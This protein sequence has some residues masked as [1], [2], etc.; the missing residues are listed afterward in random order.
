MAPQLGKDMKMRNLFSRTIVAVMYDRKGVSA[1]EYA[2]LA[3]A[4]L[5]A[6]G[7]AATTLAGDIST[8]LSN[9]GAKIALLAS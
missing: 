5:L 2:I 4:I 7:A 3:A 1:M 9:L 6:V 8:A